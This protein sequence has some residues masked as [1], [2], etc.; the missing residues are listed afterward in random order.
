MQSLVPRME[1]YPLN[2]LNR[3]F[4]KKARN[5]SLRNR[6]MERRALFWG[7]GNTWA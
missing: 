3:L 4:S 6:P 1:V 2:T 7:A 5:L